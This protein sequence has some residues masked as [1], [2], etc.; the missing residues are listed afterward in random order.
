MQ[1]KKLGELGESLAVERLESE[2]YRIRERNWRVPE[3]EIDIIAEEEGMI[4][5]V[6]VKTRASRTYGLPE[7]SITAGKRKRLI[8]AAYAYLSA[9]EIYET[10]WR[11][12]LIAIET[13][14]TGIVQRWDH[15]VDVIEAEQGDFC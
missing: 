6:E 12:D 1:A 8:K 2:G 15:Y 5:F 9:H 14:K 13:T 10:D 11:F 7:E 4:V 3:G